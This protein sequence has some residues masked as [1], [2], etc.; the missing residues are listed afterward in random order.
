[1]QP[2]A[3]GSHPPRLLIPSSHADLRAT[4]HGPRGVVLSL[5]HGGV[6]AA[7]APLSISQAARLAGFLVDH[8]AAW[9]ATGAEGDADG[10]RAR[11]AHRAGHVE[12]AD[13]FGPPSQRGEP[14]RTG[15]G[16]LA[17]SGGPPHARPE[18]AGQ[19]EGHPVVGASDR[20]AAS[21]PSA[22]TTPIGLAAG[23]R[24]AGDRRHLRPAPTPGAGQRAGAVVDEVVAAGEAATRAAVDAA[25]R[26]WR[27]RRG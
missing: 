26:A 13:R 17:E 18:T 15:S 19:R 20:T 10:G 16:H 3:G 1:M 21:H 11:D 7:S 5:W 2:A 25:R 24:D 22:P 12:A 9:T 8:V 23:S 6:C 14:T 27:A 4:W